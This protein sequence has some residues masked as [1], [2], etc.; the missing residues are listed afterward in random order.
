VIEARGSFD[1]VV[2]LFTEESEK[3][4]QRFQ[5]GVEILTGPLE[6]EV[7]QTP[8]DTVYTEDKLKIYHYRPVTE[9]RHPVPVLVTYALVNKQY[10]MD[11]QPDRSMVKKLLEQGI[12]LYMI[13]WGYPSRMDKFINMSDYING[14]MDRCV[15]FV[16]QRTGSD[17]VT[18]LGVC[19]G[20]TFSIIYTALH[21][22]KVQNLVCV[23][24]PFDFD[25]EDGLLN[26]WAR[27]M[28]IDKMVEVL[29]NV[30]GDF[31]NIGYL[32]L[33]PF[34]LMFAKYIDFM[35]HVDNPDFVS[36]F[37]RM[38]KWIF[39]SPDQAGEAIREFV[40]YFYQQ[41][42]LVKGQFKLDGQLVDPKKITVPVLNIYA[43]YDHLVPPAASEP[44][45]KAVGS[46]DKEEICLPSGHIG[47]F[48]SSKSQRLLCPSMGKWLSERSGPLAN[49][50]D[51]NKN[52]KNKN[53][54]KSKSKN[55]NK[56]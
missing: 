44:L 5:R 30:S 53:K 51:K 16:R 24:T 27:D 4:Q 12:D 46:K 19:Q 38:E 40:K 56:N 14:Y 25:T 41:N 17:K 9:K 20:G 8:H 31:M 6:V 23:V 28:D 21:Q 49:N 54:S 13:D 48:V 42:L 3:L 39:D 52:N 35:E 15:D 36:N 45:L 43:Q 29:G 7:G 33:N 22:E 11:L 26:I 34:R 18:L 2:R 47:I 10:M 55:K 37:V 32:M 50:N 1:E